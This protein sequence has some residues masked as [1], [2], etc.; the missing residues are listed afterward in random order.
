MTY[1][2]ININDTASFEKT[3]TEYD[4]YGFAGI[5]GDFNP[6]HINKR[7]AEGTKFGARIA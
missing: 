5:T 3:I 7:H 6:M 4:V 1:D 2:E